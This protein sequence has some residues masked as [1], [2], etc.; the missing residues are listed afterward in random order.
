MRG[1]VGRWNRPAFAYFLTPHMRELP[2]AT[3]K[4]LYAL[5]ESSGFGA[6]MKL[7]MRDLEIRGAG[8]IL[9]TQQSGQIST[10]GFHLY[11][12]LLK[13]A[14]EALKNKSAPSFTETKMEFTFDAALP[15]S[16]INETSLRMEIYHRWG[17]ASSLAEVDAILS[18]LKD[19]FGPYPPQVLWLYHLTR[20]RLF[21]SSHHFTLLK[22]ENLTFTAERITGKTLVK[23]TLPLS[24]SKKPDAIEK[25]I[26]DS[27]KTHFSI[28]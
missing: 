14:I 9:G 25:E 3:R 7:A 16:Y 27:L 2:E 1:R 17:E 15:E 18:E 4:R 13:R 28:N 21:A 22:F 11:C 20:L 8:D 24:R 6:G 5:A 12:K 26:I 19:R 23:K 10:I